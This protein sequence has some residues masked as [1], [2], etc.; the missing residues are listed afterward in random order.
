MPGACF[1]PT[2]PLPS[3]TGYATHT[4]GSISNE[5]LYGLASL[6]ANV[7][8]KGFVRSGTGDGEVPLPGVENLALRD[9]RAANV[10]GAGLLGFESASAKLENKVKKAVLLIVL[11]DDLDGIEGAVSGFNGS[12][13]YLG[14]TLPDSARTAAAILPI[15]NTVEEDGTFVNR[16]GRVQRYHQ[17]RSAPG[18]AQPA[19]WILSELQ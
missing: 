1:Y 12:V 8:F 11:G 9:E 14:T 10:T 3:V 13:I 5:A 19:W 15:A 16:D 18:M 7:D 17:A 2:A 6:F 4:A